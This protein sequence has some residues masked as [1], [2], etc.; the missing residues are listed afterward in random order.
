[1][2][3]STQ[4]EYGLRCLIIL[5]KSFPNE[6]G[7]TIP[8]ISQTEGISQHI[9]AKLLRVLRMGGFLI[10]E[11]GHSG[12]YSLSRPPEKIS[13][14]SVL[15]ILGG[16]LFDNEFCRNHSGTASICTNSPDC[17]VRSLWTLIQDSVDQVLNHLTLRD[18]LG[19]EDELFSKINIQQELI[20]NVIMKNE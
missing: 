12:G 11:R 18:L 13:I 17:S 2:K 20:N 6:K 16:R 1:M 15:D 10:S 4:E 5:G 8:D 3:F 9:V 7:L 19:A 14:G